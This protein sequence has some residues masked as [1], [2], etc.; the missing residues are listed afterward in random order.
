MKA[1][2]IKKKILNENN[3]NQK[4]KILNENNWN[5]KKKKNLKWK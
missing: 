1:I 2:T 5:K 4:T 3:W